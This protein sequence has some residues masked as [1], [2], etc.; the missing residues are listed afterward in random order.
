MLIVRFPYPK[1]KRF[2]AVSTK[3]SEDRPRIHIYNYHLGYRKLNLGRD[4]IR[5]VNAK[6]AVFFS[7]PMT[8][9]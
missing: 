5:T 2:T 7:V 8:I 6:S 3:E 9:A 1:S 4:S